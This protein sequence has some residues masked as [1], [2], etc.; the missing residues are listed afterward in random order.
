MKATVGLMTIPKR[1][2]GLIASQPTVYICLVLFAA[3]IG[4]FYEARTT[5]IFACQADGYSADRY[6]AYCNGTSYADYEHGAFGFGLEPTALDYA[7]KADVLFL[8]NSHLQVAFSTAATA[9]WFKASSV[10]YYLMGF[11]YYENVVFAEALLRQIKPEAKVYVI[12]V[13]DFFERWETPPAKAVLDDPDGRTHYEEKRLW[14]HIH[15]QVCGT[16]P[17][18]CGDDLVYFRS[19]TTGAYT[20]RPGRER[21][22]PVSYDQTIDQAVIKSETATAINFL[23]LL[24]VKRECVILTLTPTVGTKVGKIDAL[25]KALGED[26][27]APQLPGLKTFDGSHL[28]QPSAERWSQAFFQAAQSRILACLKAQDPGHG[29]NSP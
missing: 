11:T 1:R 18:L 14:Q 21:I 17:A 29:V 16:Y 13:D 15:E 5:T 8:G 27:V 19:R 26:L 4:L 2:A 10:S 9:D 7:R 23:P 28:D 12:N 24:P 6:I 20:K 3:F 25:V 22:T